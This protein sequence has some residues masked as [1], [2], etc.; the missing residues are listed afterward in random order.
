MPKR[1]PNLNTTGKGATCDYCMRRLESSKSKGKLAATRDH[2]HPKSLGGTYRVWCCRQC[3][4]IKGD[5]TITEWRYFRRHNPE[6]WKR[7]ELQ[8]GS[9]C[10]RGETG[11]REGLKPLSIAGSNPAERTTDLQ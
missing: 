3:N 8:F 10:A 6:W 2:V 11:R 4:Q 7:P 1:K 5:M 9:N